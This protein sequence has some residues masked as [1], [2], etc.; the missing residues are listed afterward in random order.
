MFLFGG[1]MPKQPSLISTPNSSG[2][3]GIRVNKYCVPAFTVISHIGAYP[4]PKR[5]INQ[6]YYYYVLLQVESSYLPLGAGIRK[7]ATS[8]S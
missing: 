6:H 5:S 1:T 2:K 8:S 4:P 3:L 7:I